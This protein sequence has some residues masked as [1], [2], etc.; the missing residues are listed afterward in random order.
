MLENALE[1]SM[2]QMSHLQQ[3]INRVQTENT[4]LQ[5][6]VHVLQDTVAHLATENDRLEADI[7]LLR[8]AN[9]RL[10]QDMAE[11]VSSCSSLENTESNISDSWEQL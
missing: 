11:S 10:L 9:Q 7:R 6:K 4:H 2:A 3:T 8:V 5:S 1:H